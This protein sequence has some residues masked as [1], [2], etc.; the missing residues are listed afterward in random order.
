MFTTKSSYQFTPPFPVS[1]PLSNFIVST[2]RTI[3]YSVIEKLPVSDIVSGEEEDQVAADN[4]E[5]V[6]E[7]RGDCGEKHV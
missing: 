5:D 6:H 2:T 4:E 7:N 1:P 3:I